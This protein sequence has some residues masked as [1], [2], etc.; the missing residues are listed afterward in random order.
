MFEHCRNCKPPKRHPGCQDHCPDGKADKAEYN[1]KKAAYDKKTGRTTISA[2]HQKVD[3]IGKANKRKTGK[4][5]C[6]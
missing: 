1:A 3:S 6:I 4:R 2:Y 5:F